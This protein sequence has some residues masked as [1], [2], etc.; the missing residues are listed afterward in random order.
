MTRI[1]KISTVL[2]S[3]VAFTLAQ[4]CAAQT[5]NRP[6]SD[7]LS[8]QGSTSQFFPPLPDYIGWVNNPFTTF[9][10]VDYA[11][12]AANYLATHGGPS[13]GT[14]LTG[15]VTETRLADGTY[16]VTVSVSAQNA[17]AWACDAPDIFN[18]PTIFGSRAATLLSNPSAPTA[19]VSSQLKVTFI[20]TAAG[21]PIPDL[22]G[23]TPYNLKSLKF[24]ASGSGPVPGGG[25]AKL[26]VIQSGI[27][28]T[29]FKG[30]VADGF[31]AEKVTVK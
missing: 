4:P 28:N 17:L 5:T 19:L 12:L 1:L 16:E 7:F 29:P 30:A 6:L 14:T 10:L 25:T 27:L 22:T 8:T 13:L 24:S 21:A 23:P 26:S 2:L 9:A 18:N 31:P 11:G 20:T 15:G 3:L